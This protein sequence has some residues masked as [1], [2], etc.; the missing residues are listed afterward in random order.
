MAQ[1]LFEKDS[2]ELVQWEIG[3]VSNHVTSSSEI[4]SDEGDT[5]PVSLMSQCIKNYESQDDAPMYSKSS[6]I[7]LVNV[8]VCERTKSVTYKCRLC[9]ILLRS[10]NELRMHCFVKHNVKSSSSLQIHTLAGFENNIE[11]KKTYK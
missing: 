5:N 11:K 4:S 10:S 3:V 2:S 1:N 7:N 6:D 9:S 8:G